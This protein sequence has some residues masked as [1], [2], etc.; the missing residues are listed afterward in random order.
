MKIGHVL[1]KGSS[2]N[3]NT[4]FTTPE[5]P[6]LQFIR[7]IRAVLSR[8]APEAKPGALMRTPYYAASNQLVDYGPA[9]HFGHQTCSQYRGRRFEEVEAE[10]ESLWRGSSEARRLSW[11]QARYPVRRIWSL[12]GN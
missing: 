6:A 8:R 7:N 10:L 3:M 2:I 4:R 11:D 1:C 9:Y 5:L 12:F